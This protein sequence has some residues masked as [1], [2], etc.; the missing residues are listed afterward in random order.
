M[1]KTIVRTAAVVLV[2]LSAAP[3]A[4]LADT[5]PRMFA[6]RVV[7]VEQ[8]YQWTDMSR[9]YPE[10]CDSWIKGGGVITTSVGAYTG[11]LKLDEYYA[12]KIWG[13]SPK[14]G[15]AQVERRLDYQGH[16]KPDTEE[17]SPCGP[18]SEYGRCRGEVPDENVK[19]TCG[20]KRARASTSL[21]AENRSLTFNVA[22]GLDDFQQRCPE[23]EL[24]AD[25]GPERPEFGKMTERGGTRQL[26]RLR[27]GERHTIVFQSRRGRC[28]R[29]GQ[30]GWHHCATSTA[31]VLFRRTS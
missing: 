26:L 9:G 20:P 29:I 10:K 17:C 25:P 31:K 30:R 13:H 2:L 8:R 4:A 23:V 24:P 14:E 5:L 11:L 28:D 3:A 16:L 7:S 22:A 27:R 6:Y 12:G 19:A 1:T 15:P 21:T 18:L